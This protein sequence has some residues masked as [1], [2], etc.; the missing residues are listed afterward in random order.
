MDMLMRHLT[1]A[2]AI[3]TLRPSTHVHACIHEHPEASLNEE[4]RKLRE[5]LSVF[6]KPHTDVLTNDRGLRVPGCSS[7][8]SDQSLADH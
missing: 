3:L 4:R 7:I 2:L 6:S 1:E 5:S 8:I